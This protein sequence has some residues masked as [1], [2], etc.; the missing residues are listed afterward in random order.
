MALYG[1]YGPNRHSLAVLQGEDASFVSV[2]TAH[3]PDTEFMDVL[4]GS[5]RHGDLVT[6]V[7]DALGGPFVVQGVAVYAP[8]ADM[9]M[10]GS[11]ILARHGRPG[12][13]LSWLQSVIPRAEH[14]LAVPEQITAWD[15]YESSAD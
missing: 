7:F 2:L 13:K 1:R 3:T 11:M 10:L 12:T 5:V 4:L 15:F 8:V 6:A 9:F 14:A